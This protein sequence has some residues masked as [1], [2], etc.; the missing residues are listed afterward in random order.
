MGDGLLTGPQAAALRGLRGTSCWILHRSKP[1]LCLTMLRF[2]ALTP[3]ARA[4]H[5]WWICRVLLSQAHRFL[6][7]HGGGASKTAGSESGV[8]CRRAL[9]ETCQR[10]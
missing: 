10:S 3:S 6:N 4:I 8:M 7:V 9:H 1:G 5:S 2:G